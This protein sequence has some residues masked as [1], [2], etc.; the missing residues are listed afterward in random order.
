[1]P[2]SPFRYQPL[3]SEQGSPFGSDLFGSFVKGYSTP[4]LI[5][6]LMLE[7]QMSRYKNRFESERSKYYPRLAQAETLKAEAEPGHIG[8]QT[9]LATAESQ[10]IRYILE[11]PWLMGSEE[12]KLI[13]WLQSTGQLRKNINQ[14][15]NQNLETTTNQHPDQNLQTKTNQQTVSNQGLNPASPFNTGN[16]LVDAVLNRKYA[17]SAYQ[18]KSVEGYLWNHLPVLAQNQYVAQGLGMGVD[19]RKM[20]GYV[21]KGLD[22]KEI[23]KTEGLDPNNI[24]PPYYPPTAGTLTRTQQVQQ[25]GAELNYLTS[26]T[27]P[28][29]AQYADTFAG[30]SPDRIRDMLS[31]DPA[32]QKR[33]GEYIGALSVQTGIA[34]GR[35]LL[36]G[37]KSG[38]EVMRMV[39]DSSLKG[40]DQH[41]PIK[42]TKVAYEA[43]QHKIDEVLE[44]GASIRTATGMNPFAN[45]NRSA[46][47]VQPSSQASESNSP[48][49]RSKWSP[50]KGVQRIT[51]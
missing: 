5:Q 45:V 20:M 3:T 15:P 33:F 7:N 46:Q 35:V 25:V 1:M 41:S 51:K 19:P 37:G 18:Q 44:K 2:Y 34:N 42:M 14:G 30:Y 48:G 40:I 38:L 29:I 11:H 36:E 28:L 10:K 26:A 21:N 24:P 31:N 13:G 9:G 12:Q 27:T 4:D 23:A 16:N 47:Q 17:Q 39:K 32:A 43:A 49:K 22:I 50:G 8:A 6:K